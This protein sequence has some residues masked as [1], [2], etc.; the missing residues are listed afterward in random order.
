MHDKGRTGRIYDQNKLGREK[1]LL[2]VGG[3]RNAE[4]AYGVTMKQSF[5]KKQYT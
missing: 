1:L 2:H 5:L 3:R 4:R